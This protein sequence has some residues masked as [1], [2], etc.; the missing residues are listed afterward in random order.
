MYN[1][2]QHAFNQ[3][4]SRPKVMKFVH[5][6]AR[7]SPVTCFY[8]FLTFSRFLLCDENKDTLYLPVILG[9]QQDVVLQHLAFFPENSKSKVSVSTL[10]L[11]RLC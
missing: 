1:L 6:V 3:T 5:M 4:Y 11:E 8:H 2:E 10:H 7:G 9:N